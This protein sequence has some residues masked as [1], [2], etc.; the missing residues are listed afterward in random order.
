[1]D[2]L[3]R[4]AHIRPCANRKWDLLD[5][6]V[7]SHAPELC[8][9]AFDLT[10]GYAQFGTRVPANALDRFAYSAFASHQFDVA[11]SGDSL[12]CCG[13]D[14]GG[15]DGHAVRGKPPKCAGYGECSPY[16]GWRPF[17]Y[18]MLCQQAVQ[19]LESCLFFGRQSHILHSVSVTSMLAG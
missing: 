12:E 5:I 4:R 15:Q 14:D 6:W 7:S 1:M 2:T 10:S 17:Q 3:E 11:V 13:R 18:H 16:Q 9:K 8:A 19:N